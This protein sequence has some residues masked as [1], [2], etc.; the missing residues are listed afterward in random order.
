M[1][2]TID[3]RQAIL[4][5]VHGQSEEDLRAMIEGSV[6]GPEAALPGLGVV[7]EM[8]WKDLDKAKQDRVIGMLHRHLEEVTPGSITS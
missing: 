1:P 2:V 4:H 5:K 6:N 8:V 7:F 3:L